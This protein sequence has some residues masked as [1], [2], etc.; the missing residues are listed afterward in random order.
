MTNAPDNASL[1]RSA[2]GYQQV[3]AHYDQCLQALEVPVETRYVDTS[4]GP[5]HVIVGGSETGKPLVLWH[6]LNANASTW[7]S[8]FPALAPHYRLLAV[9]LIGAMGKSAPVR[10]SKKDSSY[11]R[12]AAETLRGLGLT[13]ANVMGA[14]NG[15]WLIGKLA[16]VA[17]ELIGCA[18]LMSTAGFSALNWWGTLRML[19]GILLK[20]P[21]AAARN[22]VAQVSPPDLPADPFFLQF[23]ELMLTS[24]FISEMSGPLLTDVEIQQ[25][26]APSYLLMGQYES[27]VNPF[28]TVKRALRL[29]PNLVQAEIVPGVGHS[30][31]HPRPDWVSG[32]V[33]RFLDQYAV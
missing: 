14:S 25:L 21:A 15:G 11:G 32:R 4:F 20:P 10:P 12:W 3:L 9:D 19:P 29:L 27:L 2:V 1:Y 33:I 24:R 17:P 16:G 30:M 6:G 7:L 23:F 31:L 18:V 28:Q 8:W 13:Q 22:L 5:T 26:T